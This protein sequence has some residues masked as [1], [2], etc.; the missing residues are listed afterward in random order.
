MFSFGSGIK[1]GITLLLVAAFL[2][3]GVGVW[4]SYD[5]CGHPSDSRHAA[6]SE[7]GDPDTGAPRNNGDCNSACCQTYTA[8][9]PVPHITFAPDPRWFVAGMD[10]FAE[11]RTHT[12]IFHPPLA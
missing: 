1:G 2:L 12:D 5:C 7:T 6:G 11:S 3:A 9:F 10:E 4:A 8:V